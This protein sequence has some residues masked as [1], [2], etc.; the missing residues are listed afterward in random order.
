[1]I[2]KFKVSKLII[3]CI[4]ESGELTEDISQIGEISNYVYSEIE[5]EN[6]LKNIIHKLSPSGVGY[7]NHKECIQIQILNNPE[8]KKRQKKINNSY[9]IK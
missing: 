8:I 6:N 5:I 2:E 9:F 4:D 1:V 7:R 3:G